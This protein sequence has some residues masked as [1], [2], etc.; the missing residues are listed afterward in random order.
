[1]KEML[2]LCA[3]ILGFEIDAINSVQF[4]NHTGKH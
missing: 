1:V 4:S 3:Q 2:L